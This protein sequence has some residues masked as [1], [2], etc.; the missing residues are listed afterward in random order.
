MK[1]FQDSYK[2]SE[3]LEKGL[4]ELKK[5][6]ASQMECV[7]VIKGSLILSLSEADNIILNSKTWEKETRNVLSW[8]RKFTNYLDKICN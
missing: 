4:L 5:Q 2:K 3:D 8:R 1:I 7:K 6:G